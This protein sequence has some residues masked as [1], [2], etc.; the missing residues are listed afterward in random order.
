MP[1]NYHVIKPTCH[2]AQP[3]FQSSR[4]AQVFIAVYQLLVLRLEANLL[5]DSYCY[6]WVRLMSSPQYIEQFAMGCLLLLW[7]CGCY[8][9]GYDNSGKKTDKQ[10][11]NVPVVEVLE[12][13]GIKYAGLTF[14]WFTKI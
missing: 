13:W 14:Y 12:T 11:T 10:W 7:P 8:G 1:S 9:Y 4:E 5:D 2:V 6:Y 3:P